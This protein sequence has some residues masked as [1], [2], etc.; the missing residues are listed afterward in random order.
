MARRALRFAE[1]STDCGSGKSR[2]AEMGMS[3]EIFY[4]RQDNARVAHRPEPE[5]ERRGAAVFETRGGL[6]TIVAPSTIGGAP[7]GSVDLAALNYPVDDVEKW[8]KAA[9]IQDVA[10][11]VDSTVT[12]ISELMAEVIGGERLDIDGELADLRKDFAAKLS[13]VQQENRDLRTSIAEARGEIQALGEIQGDL[14]LRMRQ[15]RAGH[16]ASDG[17]KPRIRP[18]V[19]KRKE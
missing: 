8:G 10:A 5:P 15:G 14:E 6:R 9:R 4:K 18:K 3:P 13:E 19:S 2:A 11:T 16:G 17:A 7:A 12:M 1:N